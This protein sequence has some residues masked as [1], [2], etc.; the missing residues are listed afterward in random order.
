[1]C[2]Y[3]TVNFLICHFDSFWLP[4]ISGF[5]LNHVTL[6]T[7]ESVLKERKERKS[8]FWIYSDKDSLLS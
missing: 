1:M 7:T 8:R 6:I 3:S 2:R 4:S 5:A